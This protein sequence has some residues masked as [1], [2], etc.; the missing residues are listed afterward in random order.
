MLPV[1][2]GISGKILTDRERAMFTE[3]QP[4]GIILFKRNC[5][6]AEQII[7]LNKS[8]KE[9]LPLTKIFIDQEGG[10]VARVEPPI[11]AKEYPNMEY[12]EKI[13]QTQ[14]KESAIKAVER[15]FFELMSEL[16]TLGIDV[17]CAPVSDLRTKDGHDVIGNRSFGSNV[18]I[19]IELCKAALDGI[20][21]A[22]GEGVIKHIPGHGR[23]TKDSHHEMP[24][25]TASLEELEQTDFAVFK[26]LASLCPYA[27]TAHV[28]Y[29][30]FDAKLPVTLSP[31]AIKYIRES[32]GF[33]GQLMTDALEMKALAGDMT[34]NAAA[35]LAAGCNIVLHCTG[36]IDEMGSIAMA[37][38]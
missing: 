17:T 33:E 26:A 30:C 16:K 20:H 14:G 29:T 11:A 25:V 4:H 37:L 2:F 13:Y 1:I 15:N 8:I 28:V 12:F 23:A 34:S 5:E 35:V 21:R 7:A 32:I 22:G 27:M 10:K 3:H 38:S 19:V 36:N 6:S 31:V 24:V 9:I 18:E